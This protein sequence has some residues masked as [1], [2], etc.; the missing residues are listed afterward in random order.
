VLELI[1]KDWSALLRWGSGFSQYYG[2]YS[3]LMNRAAEVSLFRSAV[4]RM[5]VKLFPDVPR[6]IDLAPSSG[7]GAFWSRC[8]RG[9][10]RPRNLSDW[11][12]NY[13]RSITSGCLTEKLG[14]YRKVGDRSDVKSRLGL[15]FSVLA[16]GGL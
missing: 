12:G 6:P 9:F 10:N 7:S 15:A 8:P 14:T 2:C 11:S 3:V 5:P 13:Q 4:K 16:G 1:I